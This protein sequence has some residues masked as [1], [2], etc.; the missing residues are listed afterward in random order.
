MQDSLFPDVSTASETVKNTSAASLL[1]QEGNALEY[2]T[3]PESARGAVKFIL[4][5]DLPLGIDTE[6]AKLKSFSGH[7]RAGLDPTLSKI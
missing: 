6:T 7:P 1:Q 5:G 4:K 3:A 2:I